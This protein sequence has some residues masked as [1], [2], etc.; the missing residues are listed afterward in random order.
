MR[1]LVMSTATVATEVGH[2]PAE[3]D[4]PTFCAG[5]FDPVCTHDED[6]YMQAPCFGTTMHVACHEVRCQSWECGFDP[7]MEE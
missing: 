6:S 3:C 5:C 2:T 1:D 4:D 7:E